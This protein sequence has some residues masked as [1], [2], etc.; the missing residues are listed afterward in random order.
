MA[1]AWDINTGDG[2]VTLRLPQSFAADL[3]AHTGDGQIEVNFPI[4]TS[5]TVGGHDLRGKIGGGGPTLKIRTGDGG[6][7]VQRD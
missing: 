5:G 7:K 6:I 1:S 4:T 3:D 2:H